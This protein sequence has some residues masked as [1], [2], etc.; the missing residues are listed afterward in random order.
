[1]RISER[2]RYCKKN[3]IQPYVDTYVAKS[4]KFQKTVILL[5]LSKAEKGPDVK[6]VLAALQQYQQQ[7]E[8]Q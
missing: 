2:I 8:L 7:L 1:M 5:L 4:K 6:K 3:K